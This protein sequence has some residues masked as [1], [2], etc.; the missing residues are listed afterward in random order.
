MRRLRIR[1]DS[2]NCQVW[3]G[4]S[5]FQLPVSIQTAA[6]SHDTLVAQLITEIPEQH[7]GAKLAQTADPTSLEQIL[8]NCTKGKNWSIPIHIKNYYVTSVHSFTTTFLST[9]YLLLVLF[10]FAN[11]KD[12]VSGT[13]IPSMLFWSKWRHQGGFF[14]KVLSVSYALMICV[15]HCLWF[16]SAANIFHI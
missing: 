9:E 3:A 12:H 10:T 16:L 4:Q 14:P 1:L 5:G 6:R 15:L 7:Q 13:C 8:N 11:M 2:L